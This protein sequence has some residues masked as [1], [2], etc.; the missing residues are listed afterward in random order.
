MPEGPE[1]RNMAD[2][3]SKS[4]KEKEILSFRFLY[5]TLAPLADLHSFNII[6]VF[7][8]GKPVI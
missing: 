1:T 7:S 5:K 3:I 4:L 8:R 2:G 6:N